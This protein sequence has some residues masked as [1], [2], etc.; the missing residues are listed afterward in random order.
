M[1]NFISAFFGRKSDTS[2]MYNYDLGELTQD[3][4]FYEFISQSQKRDTFDYGAFA[5]F[6][7][8]QYIIGYNAGYGIG[9]H[10]SS[11]ARFM[12]DIKGGGYI[13]NIG[14]ATR[15]SDTCRFN[16]ITAKIYYEQIRSEGCLDSK[17]WGGIVFNMPLRAISEDQLKL[18][19]KFYDE[20]NED[21]KYAIQ[22]S[23]GTFS[24]SIVSKKGVTSRL[25]SLD[26]VLE[27]IEENVDYSFEPPSSKEKIVGTG[28]E[29][30]RKLK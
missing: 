18:F 24:V 29:F 9:T 27:Y 19:R 17:H 8:K 5:V 4:S 13:Y 25:D 28:L 26:K 15:L 7:D 20:Y 30:T 23:N 2:S 22:K 16:C 3:F 1:N 10:Y 11:F 14:D 21:L 12:K 6:T